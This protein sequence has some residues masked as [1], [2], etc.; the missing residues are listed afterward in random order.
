MYPCRFFM[1]SGSMIAWL[2]EH[3][4]QA[5]A[6]SLDHDLEPDE[7]AAEWID[8]GTGR[9]V[10][11]YLATLRPR[12]PVIIHS[13]NIIAARGM[14]AELETAGWPV[15]RITPYSDLTW[16]GEAW[17]PALRQAIVGRASSSA[18]STK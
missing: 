8:P 14:E 10:A 11:D 5:V 4:D 18:S 17:L 7:S 2:R 15:E 1:T 12:C 9:E 13:T 6:I 3:A 16:I